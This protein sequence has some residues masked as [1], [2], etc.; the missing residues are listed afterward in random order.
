MI[1][2]VNLLLLLNGNRMKKIIFLFLAVT[3]CII[4]W[5]NRINIVIWSIPKIL[6][7]VRPISSEGNSDWQEGPIEKD[8]SDTRPNIILILADDLGFNDIS[9][10]NGGAGSGS[11]MTPNIDQIAF[12]GVIFENGY[13]ANAMCA[14][15][16]ASIMTGRYST[17]FGFEFTPFYRFGYTL[18]KWMDPT[19]DPLKSQFKDASEENFLDEDYVGMPASEITIAEILKQEGYYNAHIGKWHL[20]GIKGQSPIEQ[21]FDDSLQ[22]LSPLYLPKND[23]DVVNAKTSATIDKM[24]WASSQYAVRFNGG[25]AFEPGGYITDYYSKEA[26]KVIEKNKNRPFFLYLG[27]FAPHNP[28]QSLKNDFDHFHHLNNDDQHNLRVYS[29]ML[30]AL[31]RGIGDI[32]NALEQNNLTCLLYTSPS[33]R[34]RG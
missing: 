1:V 23:P 14:Q 22:L 30:R 27:H 31:D 5:Q 32:L 16:R 15:S 28:M 6:N 12:D 17:R 26:I 9:F 2:L 4:I 10:Y 3:M 13:A 29:G 33:P 11:L 19:F 25:K 8:S 24:V 18:M 21:G 7:V 20:G 34:D